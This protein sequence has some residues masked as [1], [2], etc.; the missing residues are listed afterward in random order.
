MYKPKIITQDTSLT[1]EEYVNFASQ[2]KMENR[3]L[4]QNTIDG[5]SG[6]SDSKRDTSY[7]HNI[8]KSM[9]DTNFIVEGENVKI[10]NGL[11]KTGC[12]KMHDSENKEESFIS[13]VKDA[14]DIISDCAVKEKR[15]LQSSSLRQGE[16]PKTGDNFVTHIDCG[17]KVSRY[18][19]NSSLGKDKS[20]GQ[21]AAGLSG[22]VKAKCKENH[23]SR[24]KRLR[25][26][27]KLLKSSLS[28]G[29]RFKSVKYCGSKSYK[30]IS[31]SFCKK[32]KDFRNLHFS[33][34]MRVGN[35]IFG[36]TDNRLIVS[37]SAIKLFARLTP[38]LEIL[39][40]ILK[41]CFLTNLSV[42]FGNR[43][44][45]DRIR[46]CSRYFHRQELLDLFV[47][48]IIMD[49]SSGTDLFVCG[50]DLDKIVEDNLYQHLY[51]VSDYEPY[52][53]R[54]FRKI[55]D[56]FYS[57]A[58]VKL[59]Q[60]KQE[61]IDFAIFACI[62][63]SGH[64]VSGLYRILCR[65]CNVECGKKDVLLGQL[66]AQSFC[67]KCYRLKNA[68]VHMYHPRD[69]NEY[70][71]DIGGVMGVPFIMWKN[72]T[73]E[74]HPIVKEAVRQGKMDFSIFVDNMIYHVKEIVLL[75]NTRFFYEENTRMY[76]RR[77]RTVKSLLPLPGKRPTFIVE[78]NSLN[79]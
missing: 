17:K 64:M 34:C 56:I 46:Y 26:S 2:I 65:D 11:K 44:I 13:N 63:Y 6:V 68:I 24:N 16:K 75:H 5:A 22:V 55:F 58:S 60:E 36:V 19:V 57:L 62:L 48:K 4:K 70:L 20:N 21:E 3:H 37:D 8:Y 54:F 32:L 71:S 43:E 42:L 40:F 31:I 61:L 51:H 7:S 47:S 39:F 28:S 78:E 76:D 9:K 25:S 1:D 15:G 45:V 38:H 29:V 27:D 33:Y 69:E 77:I 41:V 52:S 10:G 18:S 35:K 59:S 74:V 73:K 30:K 66:K 49:V 50:L 14:T 12:F 67:D 53:G 72:L 79:M 23:L